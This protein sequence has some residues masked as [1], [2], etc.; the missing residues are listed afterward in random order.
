MVSFRNGPAAPASRPAG[1]FRR[2]PAAG[3]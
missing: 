2:P 1:V 3:L